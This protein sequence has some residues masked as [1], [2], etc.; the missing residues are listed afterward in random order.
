[1]LVDP[2]REPL[3]PEICTLRDIKLV[4]SQIICP[5]RVR[6]CEITDL[7][8][9]VGYGIQD[10]TRSSHAEEKL[11]ENFLDLVSFEEEQQQQAT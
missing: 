1:M 10:R 8:V 4:A 7:F 3:G 5:I 9:T 6:L 11:H 2:I